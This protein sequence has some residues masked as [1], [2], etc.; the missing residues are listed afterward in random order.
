MTCAHSVPDKMRPEAINRKLL[1]YTGPGSS[2]SWVWLADFLEGHRFYESQFVTDPGEILSAPVDSTL[3][4]PGGDTFRIAEAF[5]EDGLV[6]LKGKISSGMGYLG[7]CA[8]AY[9][10]LNSSIAPLSS[11][12]LLPTRISNISSALPAGIADPEKHSVRYGCSYVIHPARGPVELSGDMD[13]IAPI[14]GGP[15][16]SPSDGETVRLSFSGII[17]N[18]ELLVDRECYDSISMGKAACIEGRH[19]RGKVMAIAPHLEHPDYPLANGYLR[20]L[21]L[22]FPKGEQRE[23][24]RGMECASI[25]EARSVT[26][27][28][29]VLANSLDA[30]TWKIGVKYW[31]SDKLLFY[32]DAIRKRI[33]GKEGRAMVSPG[34][35][36][37]LQ[38]AKSC[39]KALRENDDERILQSAVDDLSMGASLFLTAHFA[40]LREEISADG[41]SGQRK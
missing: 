9:L 29:R 15:F 14:Y 30:R 22:E 17:E 18:T 11:F 1:V 26:A 2:N 19:G 12:N 16:L 4:V 41:A 3:I 7:I 40:G 25:K 36:A 33:G 34:A 27:D 39:L 37:C 35:L 10:P 23:R 28:L 31:E 38:S 32:I 24:L 5:G 13:L 21:L 6:A 8:G 20:D